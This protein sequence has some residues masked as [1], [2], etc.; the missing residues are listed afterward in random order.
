MAFTV[1]GERI[2]AIDVLVDPD[3]LSRLDLPALAD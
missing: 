2:V 3:R 1:R